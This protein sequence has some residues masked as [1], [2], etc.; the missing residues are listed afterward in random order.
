MADEPLLTEDDDA[1]ILEARID[2]P[3]VRLD[4]ALAAAFPTLSRARLQALLA[5]G[6]VRRDGQPITSG[7]AKAQ[8][9]LYA[10]VMPPVVAATPQPEAIPLTV[11]FEDADLIVI[12]K[13]P[14]MAAHPAP[15]CETGTLVNALLAH[16]GESLSG[17]GGVARPGIVH[18]LDKDTSGVMVAAKTD[19]AHAGLSA[20]FATH[21]IERTY[22][23]LTR[24]APSPEKG[25]I[26]TQIG[27]SNS[28]RKKMA[29][30]KS[31]GR[32]AITDYVVQK[33]FGQPAKAS[34][35]PLAARVACTLHTGRT[36]QIRVHLASKGSP[37]LGDPVYGSGSPAIPVRAA[38]AEVGLTRQALHAAVLG[39]VHP[40]TGEALRFE[41]APPEDMRRL[42]ELLAEL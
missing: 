40:V 21:D 29:V 41:T 14:G 2:A 30:L 26:Q 4:K 31:G 28:D 13:A 10:V 7:S 36:H 19:R 9:G 39:F 34:G 1:E 12:D 15:G 33:T 18:R 35:A 11:L 5:E 37:L 22:I 24:G 23:A 3:G 38:V 25:R 16:C 42:E 17:I 27:R 32:E 8:P 20:L 6:A